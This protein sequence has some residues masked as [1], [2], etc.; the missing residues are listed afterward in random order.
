[1]SLNSDSHCFPI[2]IEGQICGVVCNE[3]AERYNKG[4]I[5]MFIKIEFA[6]TSQEVDIDYTDFS[7]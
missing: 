3:C 5:E 7:S 6:E 2:E 1:M 4:E